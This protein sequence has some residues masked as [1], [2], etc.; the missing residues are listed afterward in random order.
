MERDMM[1]GKLM[2]VSTE[3]AEAAEAVRHG[4]NKNFN[5]EIAD[6]FIRLM[7]ITAAMGIDIETEIFQK[8][9]KNWQRPIKHGK[10]CSL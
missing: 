4:D 7:D 3:V 6:A 1:L 8:M 9:E 2:L 5:E 10:L